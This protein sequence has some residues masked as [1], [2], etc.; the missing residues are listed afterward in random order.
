MPDKHYI[1][2]KSVLLS[3]YDCYAALSFL[4]QPQP[5][6]TTEQPITPLLFSPSIKDFCGGRELSRCRFAA[7]TAKTA[8]VPAEARA[9]PADP[10]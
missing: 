8:G 7:E 9:T 4:E 3:Y 2:D 5:P 1:I 10:A 6:E